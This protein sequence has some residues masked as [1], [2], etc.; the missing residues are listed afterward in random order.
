MVLDEFGTV[1][2]RA[3]QFVAESLDFSERRMRTK[4][5]AD[6]SG[7]VARKLMV[8]HDDAIDLGRCF[9]PQIVDFHRETQLL[10][11]ELSDRVEAGDAA[12]RREIAV[13]LWRVSDDE[14]A[15]T[16]ECQVGIV[17]NGPDDRTVRGDAVAVVG[18]GLAEV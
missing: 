9:R 16:T 4:V 8:T 14:P 11:V 6:V 18:R 3:I 12:D 15:P 2:L 1:V 17:E 13:V 10:A 7:W 5:D